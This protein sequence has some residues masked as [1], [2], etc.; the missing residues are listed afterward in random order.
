ILPYLV[1]ALVE[2]VYIVIFMRYAFRVWVHGNVFLLFGLAF[3]SML[4]HLSIGLVI[5]S[6]LSSHIEAGHVLVVII[7]TQICN[8]GYIFPRDT[9]PLIFYLMSFLLPA[10]YMMDIARGIILRGAGLAELWL[11]GLILLVTGVMVLLLAAR[12]FKKMIV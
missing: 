9:M 2:M 6:K 1:L 8:Q 5:A 7:F 12:N 11:N 10:T 3:F 4:P